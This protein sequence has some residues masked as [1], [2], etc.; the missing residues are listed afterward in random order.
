MK[1][2]ALETSTEACS[3]ALA[4]DGAVSERFEIAPRKHA[5]LILPMVDGLLKDAGLRLADLDAL[6]FGRGPGAF[7]GVRIAA[8]VIQGLAFGAD[9]PV[10]PVS[11]LAALAQGAAAEANAIAAAIDARMGEVY[12]GTFTVGGDGL[13]AAAGEERVCKADSVEVPNATDWFGVGTGWMTYGEIL[14]GK[15][16]SRLRGS[17][18]DRFPS[19]QAV[20]KLATR[21]LEAGRTVTAAEALPVYLRHPIQRGGSSE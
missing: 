12:W 7:T 19:A 14:S 1:L 20:L 8:G 10:I 6:A 11:T 21:E 18:G 13:V 5:E 3:A 2:L 17:A 4:V 15:L 16:G 9:R